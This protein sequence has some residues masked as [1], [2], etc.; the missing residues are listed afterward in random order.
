MIP[1]TICSFASRSLLFL[2]SKSPIARD[3]AKFPIINITPLKK[4][5]HW[6]FQN[7]QIHLL[8]WFLLFQLQISIPVR[9]K[10]ERRKG[11]YF[12]HTVY[13]LLIKQLHV[14]FFQAL[15]VNL[16]HLQHKE[17]SYLW[18]RLLLRYIRMVHLRNVDLE[19]DF[20]FHR[21]RREE[22]N[23]PSINAVSVATKPSCNAFT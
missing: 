15:S 20:E 17:H 3:N 6:P 23:V 5:Y 19:L 10:L 8:L 18:L 22:G 21:E 16:L 11:V 13:D 14:L 9:H 4:G 12:L 2:K 7:L 1:V